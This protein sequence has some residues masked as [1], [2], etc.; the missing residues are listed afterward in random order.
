MTS[1]ES[2]SR[3][4]PGSLL[5]LSVLVQSTQSF[6]EEGALTVLLCSIS[7][8]VLL[9]PRNAQL[10]FKPRVLLIFLIELVPAG[11]SSMCSN[12]GQ[13]QHVL[14]VYLELQVD[15]NNESLFLSSKV[16]RH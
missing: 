10:Y 5:L 14:E 8:L 9:K 2:T 16:F 3:L 11:N 7:I 4:L 15:I 12:T 13:L 1:N 6:L